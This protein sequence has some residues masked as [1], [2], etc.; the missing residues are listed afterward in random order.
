MLLAPWLRL[1]AGGRVTASGKGMVLVLGL[2]LLAGT[3]GG[4]F[5]LGFWPNPFGKHHGQEAPDQRWGS[6][7]GQGHV[8]GS[9]G[10]R[11]IPKTLR[12]KYPLRSATV[13]AATRNR[14]WVAE[15]P[16]GA[17]PVRGFVAETSR[18]VPAWRGSHQRG[19]VNADGTETSAFSSGPVNYWNRRSGAWEPID[20]QL[21][22]AGGA[23][24]RNAADAVD[25][26]LAER[27]DA[28]QVARLGLDDRHAVAFGVAGARAVSGRAEGSAV[29][30]RDALAG[31]VDVRLESAPGGVKETLVLRSADGPRRYV[32]PLALTGLSAA[33]DN[34]QVVFTDEAGRRRAIIP[35]GFMWDSAA[36]RARSEGVAYRLVIMGG[37]PAL[38]VTLDSAWLNDPARRYPVMVDPTVASDG[39]DST[40]VVREDSDPIANGSELLVGRKDEKAAASYLKFTGVA[41]QLQ[42]HTIFGAQL[43][44]VNFDSASCKARSVSVHPV[45]QSWSTSTNIPYPGP[46]V[47]SALTSSSFAYGHIA[48]GQS[49]SSCPTKTA[50]FNLGAAGRTLVQGWANGTPNNGLSLRAS[51]SD[52]LGW[53]R[54]TGMGT[55]N[56]PTLYVTHSPYNAK[57]AIPDPVPQPPVLQN[58]AG[59][60]KVTVTHLGAETWTPST[61]YL[62]YRAYNATT[63]AAVTQQRAANLPGNLSRGGKV[64]LEATIKALPPGKY[65]LDFTMVRSGGVVFTDEQ[66]PPGR[67]V[68]EVIDVPP[69]LQE[70]YPPNGYQ[71]PTLSPQ[72]WAQAVDLDAPPGTSLQYKFEL[73]DQDASGTRV[74]C[75]TSAY[76]TSPAWT[77]PAGRLVWS[78]TYQ[79]KA[80]VKDGTTEV[81]SPYVT[82]LT[83]VPQPAVTSNVAGSPFASAEREFDPQVGNFSTTAVDA[84]VTT[85]GPPLKIVR[86]YNSL[87]PRR[88]QVDDL[89]PRLDAPFGA[90]WRTQFDMRLTPDDDGSGN[91]VVSYPDGQEVRFGKN[92]DGTYA[93]PQGRVASLTFTAATSTWTLKD[94]SNTTY[95]FSSAGRLTKI[96]GISSRAITLTY[97]PQDGRLSKAQVTIG[98]FAGRA[99]FFTWTGGHI[100]SVRTDPVDGQALTWNYT[101]TGDQLTQVCAPGSVCT[102]YEYGQQGSHYRS[103]VLDDKPESYWR[104]GESEGTGAGSE[105]AVNL[106][107]DRGVY[108][109]VTLAAPGT[110]AG[111]QDTAAS[112]NGTSSYVELPK[113]T[114]KKIRDAAVEVWFRATPTSSG[115]P[116]IGYQDKAVGTAST[117]GVPV[118][119][120]GTDG[121]LHGQF[122]NG[123]IAPM[124]GPAVNDGE[125]HHAVLSSMGATQTLYLDGEQ[126][127]TTTNP[128]GIDTSKLTFN[129]VGAAFASSPASWP[130]WGATSQ[131]FF[132]GT[133]DDVAVYDH[134]LS[135]TAVSAHYQYGTT[136]AGRLEKVRLPSGRVAAEVAYDGATGRVSEYT[137]R[138]GG[139]WKVGAPTVYGGDT[140]LRRGVEVRDPSD[141][142]YLYE[143]DALTGQMI[144]SG[145]PTGQVIRDEDQ[146]DWTPTPSPAPTPSTVCTTPDPG[147]PKFC[148]TIPPESEGPV[149]EGHTLDGMAIR[150]Y[151]YADNGFLREVI[152]ENGRTVTM[153][154]DDR[155]NVTSRRTCRSGTE[156]YTEFLTYPAAPA[157]LF[158]PLSYLPTERRDA[159]SSGVTDNRFRTIYTYHSTGQLL[160]QAS[161]GSGTVTHTYTNAT[162]VAIGGGTMPAGLVRTTRDPRN[163]ETLYSYNA[164]G[165]LARVTAPS[166]LVTTFTY[167]ALGRKISE[168]EVSDTFPAGLTRTFTYDALSQLASVTEPVTA[169]AVAGVNHRRKSTMTYDADGNVTVTKVEDLLGGD[170]ARVTTREY[171]DHGRVERVID[172]EGNE[173][174]FTHDRFGNRTS[175]VDANDNRYEYG[176][177]ARN[178]IAEVRLRDW[179]DDPD[180]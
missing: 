69:V 45:T 110:I 153:T 23:G 48:L 135:T 84:S 41:S 102:T 3:A 169:D 64:T 5:G 65:F 63:G 43:S 165:D 151:S 154:H 83:H 70:L 120:H 33:V 28:A 50:L 57:Y 142:P 119:Y 74:N 34:G 103:A 38:E 7:A 164:H 99:L 61:Y 82:L 75:T 25:V 105:V 88:G 117:I 85:I 22:R 78:K 171:D 27:A 121:R 180:G 179:D 161:P 60:V 149:F 37:R 147:D 133:I 104:L 24:W 35:A 53:K 97:N 87:D 46:S 12:A 143:F 101:Y 158:S 178:Q 150:S 174:V 156:C 15:P 170:P 40:L 4:G 125:W 146:A 94:T 8:V 21:V 106:G 129:Q 160:T 90:G 36:D 86:T 148:T 131:R 108:R 55:A 177:T 112:F 44:A 96:T 29:T 107:K 134:P 123:T 6:A 77:P 20:P 52:D 167:D 127:A 14:A 1:R 166:G 2:A 163:A 76:Q 145:S 51:A 62:A 128:A 176:Y 54:F 159:R 116:L 113:G 9:P 109:N 168:T 71:T 118:L 122:W 49:R 92:P 93:A 47:G 126:V 10:N 13:P 124:A 81:P 79:W 72:L 132:N 59:K 26:R 19:Y 111:S 89:E 31:R 17:K 157:D 162:E 130:S 152:N 56:P 39:A 100:T 137:D 141:R 30:Y 16:S 144:R 155:G 73:C 18:E 98:Q 66:V 138:D 80:F 114:V 11:T 115:G 95:T 42:G 136:A 58:Q 139:T 32:F 173:T 67:I 172:P 68:L 91:V 175:M 140:D